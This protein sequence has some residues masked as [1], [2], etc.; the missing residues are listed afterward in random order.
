ML[1][2]WLFHIV[3]SLALATFFGLITKSKSS[4]FSSLAG[5]WVVQAVLYFG[6]FLA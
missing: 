1:T 5:W 6:G 2:Y 3:C 4:F